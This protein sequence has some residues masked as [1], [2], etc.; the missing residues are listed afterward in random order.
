[1]GKPVVGCLGEG[2]PDDLH[3]LGDCIELVKSHDVPSLAAALKRLIDDPQR[4]DTMGKTGME[5]VRQYYSWEQTAA[6]SMEIYL[7]VLE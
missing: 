5:I 2:G 4:R 1:M 6:N 7:R 3:S